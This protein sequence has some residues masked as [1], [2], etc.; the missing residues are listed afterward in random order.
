M[1]QLTRCPNCATL[2]RV[3]DAQLALRG[4]RVRCGHCSFVF[5]ARACFVDADPVTVVDL[6]GHK[7]NEPLPD[8]DFPAPI[9]KTMVVPFPAIEVAPEPEPKTS[10]LDSL[11]E[12][13]PP[14]WLKQASEPVSE[15]EADEAQVAETDTLASQLNFAAEEEI[16]EPAPIIATEKP[17]DWL[18]PV[19]PSPW[20]WFWRFACL[21]CIGLAGVLSALLLRQP[22]QEWYPPSRPLLIAACAQMRCD[23]PLP[24]NTGHLVLDGIEFNFDPKDKTHLELSGVLRNVAPYAQAWPLLDVQLLDLQ[25]HRVARRLLKPSQYLAPT[26]AKSA[27]ISSE[28]EVQLLVVLQLDPKIRVENYKVEVLYPQF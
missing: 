23:V 7:E 12:M 19:G 28:Q 24:Q 5:N 20:R 2:F 27:E 26:E 16:E 18:K 10:V 14:N 13:S 9:S 4:G 15:P 17:H 1:S 8:S 22:L 21:V 11:Q 3:S 25:G 6:S